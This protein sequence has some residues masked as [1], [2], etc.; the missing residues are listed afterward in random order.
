MCAHHLPQLPKCLALKR[1]DVCREL[2]RTVFCAVVQC[3][4]ALK[5]S[6]TSQ[7][8]VRPLVYR[9]KPRLQVPHGSIGGSRR[10]Q[11]RSLS[12]SK[13]E[14]ALLGNKQE[15]T[16]P[17]LEPGIRE[18]SDTD[19]FQNCEPSFSISSA[20]QISRN[21]WVTTYERWELRN[22]NSL[23]NAWSCFGDVDPNLN[24]LHCYLEAIHFSIRRI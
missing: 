2:F 10:H 19:R 5:C 13:I 12:S 18:S 8:A 23:R 1:L 6:K 15:E 20:E 3:S 16:I 14:V 17:P 11:N 24:V 9:T 22:V 21:K 4:P 7:H